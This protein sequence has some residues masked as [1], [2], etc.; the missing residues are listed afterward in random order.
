MNT[1][2]S[3]LDALTIHVQV[4]GLEQDGCTSWCGDGGCQRCLV[5]AGGANTIRWRSWG[6]T[7]V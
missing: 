2:I 7:D 5:Q 4:K 3:R 6:W 1:R